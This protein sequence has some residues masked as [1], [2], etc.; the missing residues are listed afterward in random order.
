MHYYG[1]KK[2]FKNFKFR[3]LNIRIFMN[4]V[5][6][7]LQYFE[8]LQNITLNTQNSLSHI[9]NEDNFTHSERLPFRR[10]FLHQIRNETQLDIGTT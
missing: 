1:N 6:Q 5:N 8:I 3:S 10:K 7:I 9:E 4:N 2:K